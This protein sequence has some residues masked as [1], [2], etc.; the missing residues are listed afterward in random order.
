[1]TGCLIYALGPKTE[2][3]WTD[4]DVNQ[5]HLGTS[6]ELGSRRENAPKRASKELE[7]LKCQTRIDAGEQLSRSL[8]NV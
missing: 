3:D 4:R 8:A 6:P 1:M 5:A 7:K 2:C